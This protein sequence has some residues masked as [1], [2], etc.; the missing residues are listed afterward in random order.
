MI[1][2]ETVTNFEINQLIEMF[3]N[4]PV[5]NDVLDIWINMSMF[6]KSIEKNVSS[7]AKYFFTPLRY[8]S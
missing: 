3:A 4:C 8:F 5:Q 2:E 6:V 7:L 1:A